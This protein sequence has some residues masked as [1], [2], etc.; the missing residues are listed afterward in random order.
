M[1]INANRDTN[2]SPAARIIDPEILASPSLIPSFPREI[3][4]TATLE[5]RIARAVSFVMKESGKS[6]PQLAYEMSEFLGEDI[7]VNMLNAYGS[8]A[9]VRHVINVARF[10]GL[11]QA[12]KDMRLLQMIADIFGLAVLP[13][14]MVGSIEDRFW[15][16]VER[17]A[18]QKRREVADRWKIQQD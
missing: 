17:M 5:A 3:V 4:K 14:E 18:A 7:G 13:K 15:A 12:T 8:E 2:H 6:R 10:I 16:D 1:L 11:L 9:R